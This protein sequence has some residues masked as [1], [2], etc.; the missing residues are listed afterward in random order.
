MRA[1]GRGVVRRSVTIAALWSM[2]AVVVGA[3]I[4]LLAGLVA[5]AVV[6]VAWLARSG[7]A[8]LART[9]NIWQA[10][11]VST[12]IAA[13]LALAVSVWVAAYA[14]TE[15]GSRPRAILAIVGA[16][17]A[18]TAFA[19]LES[20]GLVVAGLGMGWAIAI[21]A[22]RVA[23]VAVRAVACLLAGL[24]FPDIGALSGGVLAVVLVASPWAAALL[25]WAADALWALVAGRLAGPVD[26]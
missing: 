21:P 3:I 5:A 19:L 12:W 15:W 9:E 10:A 8:E 16:A 17:V 4:V 25:C 23:R 22:E 7:E 20:T 18:T 26:H 1:P 24:A 2:V 13:G 11:G 14:S 6:G